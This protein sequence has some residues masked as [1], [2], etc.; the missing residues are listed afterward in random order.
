MGLVAKLIAVSKE[1]GVVEMAGTNTH[2]KYKFAKAADIIL[3]VNRACAENGVLMTA[4]DEITHFEGGGKYV[5]V[6]CKLTFRDA[7]SDELITTQSVGSGTDTG[8]KA[9]M[10]AATAAYKYAIAH[11]FTMAWGAEDPE[12]DESTDKPAPGT[13]EEKPATRRPTGRAA[14]TEAPSNDADLVKDAIRAA[15][16]EAELEPVRGAVLKLRGTPH[17]DTLVEEFRNRMNTLKGE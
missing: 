15:E 6:K 12:A 3:K 8:D 1:V 5:A 11:A 14:K 16:S 10:K 4:E 2:F 7:E 13:R 17:Y 9:A